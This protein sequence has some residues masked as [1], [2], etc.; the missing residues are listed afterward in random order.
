MHH[1]LQKHHGVSVISYNIMKFYICQVAKT[2]LR[3]FHLSKPT[4]T[5][6]RYQFFFLWEIVKFI[7]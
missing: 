4:E 5:N 7:N 2:A 6:R 3:F 1:Q